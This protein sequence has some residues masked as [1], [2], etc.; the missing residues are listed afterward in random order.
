M[1][2]CLFSALF[3][4]LSVA[5][6]FLKEKFLSDIND[7]YSTLGEGPKEPDRANKFKLFGFYVVFSIVHIVSMMLVMTMNGW[8]DLFMIAAAMGSYFYCYSDKPAK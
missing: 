1:I 4:A 5:M 2:G 3:A 6:P 7:R 8:V